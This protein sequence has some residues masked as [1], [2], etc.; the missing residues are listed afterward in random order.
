MTVATKLT[1][2]NEAQDRASATLQTVRDNVSAVGAEAKRVSGE[3][4]K[5]EGMDRGRMAQVRAARAARQAA[6]AKDADRLEKL[7]RSYARATQDTASRIAEKASAAAGLQDRID[8]AS[9]AQERFNKV[10][11]LFGFA[12]VIGGAVVALMSLIETQSRYKKA[13]DQIN[14]SQERYLDLLRRV[15]GFNEEERRKKLTEAERERL[16]AQD[17]V[18]E[19]TAEYLELQGRVAAREAQLAVARQE[20]AREEAKIASILERQGPAAEKTLAVMT[21]R[22]RIRD[23]ERDIAPHLAKQVDAKR[24]LERASGNIQR[25]TWETSAQYARQAGLINQARGAVETLGTAWSKVEGFVRSVGDSV[26]ES[27]SKIGEKFQERLDDMKTKAEEERKRKAEAAGRAAAADRQRTTDEV[28]RMQD[29]MAKRRVLLE[30]ESSA[31]AKLKTIQLERSIVDREFNEGRIN[32]LQRLTQLQDLELKQ[33]ELYREVQREGAERLKAEEKDREQRDRERAR[34]LREQAKEADRKRRDD[35]KAR[36]EERAAAIERLGEVATKAEGPLAALDSRLA[37]LGSTVRETAALWARYEKGQ[38]NLGAAIA[39]TLGQVGAQVAQAIEDR[40]GQAIVEGG[41]NA[42]AAIAA[43][44]GGNVAAGIGYSKAA[45]AFF[46]LAGKGGA[47]A[48]SGGGGGGSAPAPAPATTDRSRA[49]GG[50]GG[51]GRVTN[52]IQQFGNGVVFGMAADVGKAS[53]QAVDTL[54]G[55]GMYRRRF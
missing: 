46:A 44:A 31:A 26:S 32:N 7:E 53:A 19:K 51:G 11:A 2:I 3:M 4:D 52:I 12:G 50:G 22:M 16:E 8:A 35:E 40:R 30:T 54:R 15:A 55:S 45:L 29:D 17:R 10:T 1:I 36:L 33:A 39:G 28:R 18:L 37:G 20:I 13:L 23:I 34:T 47:G 41:F 43:F 48:G 6:M 25:L 21:A 24:E 49:F 27:A 14:E 5:L 38:E 9:R 42:A